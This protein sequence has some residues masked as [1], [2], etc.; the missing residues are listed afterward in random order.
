[1]KRV[2]LIC[3]YF[4]PLG[5]GGVGRPLQ[6]FRRLPA[7]GWECHILT[8]KPVAYRAYEPDLLDGLDL[9]R[10]HRAGSRD[11]QRL[12]Y[13]LGV[14]RLKPVTIERARPASDR[15]FPDSKVGWVKPA[16]RLGRTVIENQRIDLLLSTSP[17]ISAHLVGM[18]LAQEFR[19]PWVADFRDYWTVRTIEESYTRPGFVARAN[20][21]LEDIRKTSR[22]RTAVNA[23]IAGYVGGGE[24]IPNGYDPELAALWNDRVSTDPVFVAL[25]GHQHQ[26]RILHPLL[27]ILERLRERSPETFSRIAVLQVGQADTDALRELFARSDMAER[28]HCHGVLP[29]A[30]TV[31]TLNRAAVFYLG[32]DDRMFL[33]GRIFDMLVSG[34]PPLVVGPEQ[35]EVQRL[36]ARHQVGCYA[37]PA[38]LDRAGEWLRRHVQAVADDRWSPAPRPAFACEYSGERMAERF[39]RLMDTLV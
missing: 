29:R 1:M 33:P 11:P 2:L 37:T 27:E 25:L 3:Y 22:A 16:V 17:P 10:I 23:T 15:F 7:F 19:L 5:L 13:L 6:L 4:P 38:T 21:L 39:A 14:R 28:L 20:R 32:L 34:R 35:S 36:L 9:S 31:R 8:V 12:L 30:E 24:A 18:Q 26:T